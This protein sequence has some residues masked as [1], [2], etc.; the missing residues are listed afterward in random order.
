[1]NEPRAL[2]EH[3]FRHES[4]RLVAVLTRSLGI[5]RLAL[6]E[7]VVQAALV[8]ALET[9]SRRGVPD[10]PAG[11]L[12]RTARNLAIDALRRE[13][14]H[15]RALPRLT[16]DAERESAPLEPQFADEIGDEPLRLLF[17]S[18]HEE[19]PA[20]SRVAIAL[21][22]LCGFSTSEIARALLTTE[23]NV[24]K[25][26]ER[27]RDRLRELDVDFDTPAA[28]QL[29]ARLDAVL[30][31]VY[32]LFSQGCH[33]THG[34]LPIRRDLCDEARRLTRMLA[35]HPVGDVPAV[36]AL[37]ALMCFHAARFDAR[38]DL[39]GAIVLLEEQNRSTWNWS[40]VRE[41][42]EWLGKPAAGDELTR[43]HVE[44]GIAWEHC[45]A[46]TFADTDWRRIAE[47]Y[48]MLERIAP[49]P[50]HA[51][52]RAVAEAYLHGPQAGLDRLAAVP[53]EIVPTRY[54]GWYVVIG[55]FHFRLGQRA[56]AAHAWR[57]ALS[58]TTA[59][60]DQEFLRRRLEST[61]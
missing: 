44:A 6:V 56:D 20:E 27:A 11:W 52:N 31:V 54:P 45:R 4:G 46:A 2:V 37:L 26:I 35:A 53:K 16:D 51:L 55:E 25:R 36:Y 40:D 13:R 50:L 22:T 21:K 58:L 29:D 42:M 57:E 3:F 23:A 49:S 12:Y 5:R 24:Q 38:V 1:M 34:E 60:A 18:C 14:V 47:L 43:Y 19:V 15:D 28:D 61:V 8:Q 10:E 9:W 33:V 41:G 39:D 59:R 30:A 7:D 32:L 48:D 17:V